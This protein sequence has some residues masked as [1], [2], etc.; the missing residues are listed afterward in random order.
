MTIPLSQSLERLLKEL[1]PGGPRS[2]EHLE[3]AIENVR[4]TGPITIHYAGGKPLQLDFGSPIRVRLVEGTL[5]KHQGNDRR[6]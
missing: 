5:D 3:Q 4:F 2:R 1:G 6:L